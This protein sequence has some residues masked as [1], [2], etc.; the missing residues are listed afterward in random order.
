M[1][2]AR[3]GQQDGVVTAPRQKIVPPGL[4][5]ATRLGHGLERVG[6]ALVIRVHDEDVRGRGGGPRAEQGRGQREDD[7][8]NAQGT[9]T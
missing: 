6:A 3:L 8:C 5:P 7:R 9:S 1:S 4:E 2:E